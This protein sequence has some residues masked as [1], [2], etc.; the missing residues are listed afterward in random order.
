M[1]S[2]QLTE[3]IDQRWTTL[4]E[5]LNLGQLQTDAIDAG[6]MT[7]LMRILSRKQAP[8][9]RLSE[10]AKLLRAA[11]DDD[12]TSRIWHSQEARD[13]CR[14]RQAQCDEMHLELLAI[15]AAC[16]STLQQNRNSIQAEIEQLNA[17]HQAAKKY[18]PEQSIAT[19]GGRLDLSE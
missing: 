6:R 9:N 7:D 15:E 12:P 2:S 3:L 19:S 14:N 18:A 13:V 8:L 5:L 1:E 11:A 17:S 10:L 4:N 16:E